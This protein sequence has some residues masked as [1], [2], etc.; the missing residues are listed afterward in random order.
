MPKLKLE[1]ARY[2]NVLVG[3]V[4]EIEDLENEAHSFGGYQIC[5][6][7]CTYLDEDVLYVFGAGDYFCF[8]YSTALEASDAMVRLK[9]IVHQINSG[10]EESQQREVPVASDWEVIE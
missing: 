2:G 9:A 7:G 10:E 5:G 6:D 4:V 1:M 3:L 8:S